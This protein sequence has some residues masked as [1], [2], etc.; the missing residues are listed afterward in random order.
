M[1]ALSF[2]VLAMLSVSVV[3][4]CFCPKYCPDPPCSPS[5]YAMRLPQSYCNDVE[6]QTECMQA[7]AAIADMISSIPRSVDSYLDY[8]VKQGQVQLQTLFR[9][10]LWEAIQLDKPV[11]NC[12]YGLLTATR[13]ANVDDVC[14]SRELL[15]QCARVAEAAQPYLLDMH[16]VLRQLILA[17]PEAVRL[18]IVNAN[19]MLNSNYAHYVDNLVDAVRMNGAI[20]WPEIHCQTYEATVGLAELDND[21]MWPFLVGDRGWAAMLGLLYLVT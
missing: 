3:A 16:K 18:G 5:A 13:I 17:D 11:A 15:T 2:L 9:A 7:N 12:S 6:T 1:G 19:G 8:M 10:K 4:R 14:L 20:E 21:P